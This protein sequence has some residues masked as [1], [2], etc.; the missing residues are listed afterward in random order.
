[1]KQQIQLIRINE[2]MHLKAEKL[3]TILSA[4]IQLETITFPTKKLLD[5]AQEITN[6][7]IDDIELNKNMLK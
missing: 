7:L 2:I 6:E 5:I 3:K 1:M 4:L